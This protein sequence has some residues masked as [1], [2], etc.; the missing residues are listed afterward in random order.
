MTATAS[1]RPT[2]RSRANRAFFLRFGIGMALYFAALFL[3]YLAPGIGIPAW[4][5]ALLVVPAVS[6]MAWSNIEMYRSGDEFERRKIAEAILL[7]FV[8]ATPLI[9]AV[10][11]LQF[12][13]LPSM[14]WIFAFS[15]L[16]IGWL[17]GTL[18]SAVRY[19]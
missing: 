17:V 10:G 14:N 12:Y 1:S 2:A 7:A 11:V 9:L 16:M 3:A 15:I 18:V 4:I 13:L 8:V 6:F 19:R 5:P